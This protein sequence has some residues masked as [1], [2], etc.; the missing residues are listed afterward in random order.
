MNKIFF[1]AWLVVALMCL[2]FVLTPP[3]TTISLV[4]QPLIIAW[5]LKRMHDFRPSTWN[6]DFNV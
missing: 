4:G 3:Y 2:F 6:R 5:S 1:F